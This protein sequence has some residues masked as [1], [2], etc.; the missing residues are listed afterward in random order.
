MRGSP[1]T[2]ANVRTA[3]ERAATGRRQGE[4]AGGRTDAHRRSPGVT[5]AAMHRSRS[6][7]IPP[8]RD[9][10]WQDPQ[11]PWAAES[12]SGLRGGKASYTPADA[13]QLLVA[14]PTIATAGSKAL[15]SKR[16]RSAVGNGEVEQRVWSPVPLQLCSA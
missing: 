10:A 12:Q 11:L 4:G 15:R 13:A 8:T 2:Q 1:H 9:P 5:R 6:A 7:H 3:V 16:L 14:R